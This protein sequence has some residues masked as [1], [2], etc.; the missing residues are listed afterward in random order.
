MMNIDDINAIISK[1]IEGGLI[2]KWKKENCASV[3]AETGYAV[4]DSLGMN[5]VSAIFYFVYFPGVIG[6]T[7]VFLVEHFVAQKMK[8]RYRL[9]LWRFLSRL[10][11]GRRYIWK[12]KNWKDRFVVDLIKENFVLCVVRTETSSA[13]ASIQY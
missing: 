6:S 2:V 13:M 11:D 1:V 10:C 8:Q 4:T 7:I 9:K 3:Q 12:I 5:Y